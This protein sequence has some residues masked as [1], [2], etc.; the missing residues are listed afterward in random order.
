VVREVD[1]TNPF[2]ESTVEFSLAK[3]IENKPSIYIVDFRADGVSSRAVIRRGSIVA[4][5]KMTLVGI[6][7]KFYE[8]DSK[9]INEL[10]VW[11]NNK[12]THV[13][14][15]HVIPYGTAAQNVRLIAVKDGFAEVV[16]VGVPAEG[17]KLNI[18]YVYN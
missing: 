14:D 12:L 16:N 13:K 18:S 5:Q 10:D 6:E 4:L 2:K 7:I 11:C 9:P 15:K 3:V 1:V 8:E 17:Y